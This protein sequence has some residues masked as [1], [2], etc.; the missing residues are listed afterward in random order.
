VVLLGGMEV[1]NTKEKKIKPY[2]AYGGRILY[3]CGKS[4]YSKCLSVSE[5][6]WGC[7]TILHTTRSSHIGINILL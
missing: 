3:V 2:A 5:F 4:A 6:V 1:V 7:C